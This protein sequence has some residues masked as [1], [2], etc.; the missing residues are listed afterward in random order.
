MLTPDTVVSRRTD[1]L[2]ADVGGEVVLMSVAHGQYYGLDPVASDVWRRI[3]MPIAIREL[4]ASLADEYEGD[5][6]AIERDVLDLLARLDADGFL[7]V[8]AGD[9]PA[10]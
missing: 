5:R 9:P 2:A 10:S 7:D 1:V 4:C 8:S 3:A 6:A